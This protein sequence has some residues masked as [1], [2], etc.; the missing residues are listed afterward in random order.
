MI[1]YKLA[2]VFYT[3]SFVQES[4]YLALFYLLNVILYENIF[5]TRSYCVSWLVLLYLWLSTVFNLPYRNTGRTFCRL[6]DRY[7]EWNN[8]HPY[9][10]DASSRRLEWALV[11]EKQ[12][13][14]HRHSLIT[15]TEQTDRNCTNYTV[16]HCTTRQILNLPH[17]YDVRLYYYR[18]IV[19]YYTWSVLAL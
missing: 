18:D 8:R 2:L 16:A 4:P 6:R 10:P 3:K 9:W 7:W 1:N 14:T 12:S 19:L 13:I 17:K 15:S 11:N 5:D